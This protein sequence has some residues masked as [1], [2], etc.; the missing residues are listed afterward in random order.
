MK[1][2]LQKI[3]LK[4]FKGVRDFELTPGGE[5]VSISG[6]NGT[7][8][9]T[10]QDAFLWVLFNY[11]SDGKTDFNI[12][13]LEN[14]EPIHGLDHEVEAVLNI[15]GLDVSLRKVYKEKWNKKK[16]EES[17]EFTGHETLYYFN[18]VPVSM[19]D[20][21]EKV[22]DICSELIFKMITNPLAFNSLKW[23]DRRGI[24]FEIAESPTPEE[25]AS[26]D[27]SLIDLLDDLSGKTIDELKKQVSAQ[28]K[29]IKSEINEI[30]TRINEIQRNIPETIDEDLLT[31]KLKNLETQVRE[32][33]SEISD[34]SKKSE[35]ENKKIYEN[36]NAIHALK[37]D[38]SEIE[39]NIKSDYE[40]KKR[41]HEKE[42]KDY[43]AIVKSI[44]ENK[45]SIQEK[46]NIRDKL[47]S[48]T[49]KKIQ[50]LR[51]EW[52]SE[53][54]KEL[55]FDEK[56]FK[57]PACNRELES[58]S[59]E[60]KQK[61][62]TERFNLSKAEKL[63][64]ISMAGKEA[65]SELETIEK[66][67][68][69]LCVQFDQLEEMTY[70]MPPA[71]VSDSLYDLINNN[72][73]IALRKG[74]I[75]ELEAEKFTP[76]SSSDLTERKSRIYEEITEIKAKLNLKN[77]IQKQENRI[78]ELN[79][80]AKELNQELAL[81]E[82]KEYQCD[83]FINKMIIE[84]ET[85]INSLFGMA[86]FKMFKELVNG[87][88]EPTCETTYKGVPWGDL[89]TSAKINVGLD[90][91]NT[92][93]NHF[94]VMAPVIIDNAESINKVHEIG[95]QLIKLYVSNDEKLIIKN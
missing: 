37:R 16:G 52:K 93:G 11:N 67:I 9:T 81:F 40:E 39:H 62:L 15:D 13:T 91:I 1:I 45:K 92:L 59:I 26:K 32:I 82:K 88:F 60:G 5:S 84:T 14:G 75:K 7:G 18:D 31:G 27:S 86:K 8:K 74:R 68:E 4:N 87:S 77:E 58:E 57:C 54:S 85:K 42:L 23:Q 69:E 35:A 20:Y 61:E 21:K 43:E 2:K 73:E 44:E 63:K 55:I 51:D 28:K 6:K 34:I 3:K 95:A 38:I 76:F 83:Q 79:S 24:L 30:P 56:D 46:I 22:E 41:E 90:I 71:S 19:K 25:I 50:Q 36:Q 49:K 17:P 66:Q 29:R 70:E 33:E 64:T 65:A 80:K 53:N 72:K 48:E 10:I 12:K 89:N 78:K 94:E 47:L